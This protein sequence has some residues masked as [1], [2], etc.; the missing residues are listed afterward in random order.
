MKIYFGGV[1]IKKCLISALLIASS[2]GVNAQK[3]S[4]QP[5]MIRADLIKSISLMKKEGHDA[6]DIETCWKRGLAGD[7]R[8]LSY[9]YIILRAQKRIKSQAILDAKLEVSGKSRS[10]ILEERKKI[11]LSNGGVSLS[12]MMMVMP[13]AMKYCNIIPQPVLKGIK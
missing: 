13:E 6:L 8:A 11:Q 9:T 12:K 2:F 3:D 1:M 7:N 10:E 4:Y 5:L